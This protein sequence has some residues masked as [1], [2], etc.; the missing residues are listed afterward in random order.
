[1]KIVAF[2]FKC[3][4]KPAGRDERYCSISTSF[5]SGINSLKFIYDC[6]EDKPF[7]H[8]SSIEV[9]ILRYSTYFIINFE[10]GYIYP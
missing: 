3:D 6:D 2:S 5:A 4:S 9:G 10:V 1:M 8:N 7:S